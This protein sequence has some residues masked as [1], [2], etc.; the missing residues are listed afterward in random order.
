M[1]QALLPCEPFSDGELA[2]FRRFIREPCA[3][4]NGMLSS[5]AERW[6]FCQ[7]H[8]LGLL[9]VCASIPRS[10]LN[11][12]AVLYER[13]TRNALVMLRR[14]ASTGDGCGP[15]LRSEESC[16]MCELGLN[17]NSAGLIRR[18]WLAL[19]QSLERLRSLLNDT[20]ERWSPLVCST[21]VHLAPGPLCRRHMAEALLARREAIGVS[22]AGAPTVDR[23]LA[24]LDAL[25][26]QLSTYL[27]TFLP[28]S[29]GVDTGEGA[30]A[31]IAAAGWCTGWEMLLL[32]LG[33]R[34][35][36]GAARRD[37]DH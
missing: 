26:Q 18:E 25:E 23:E 10:G 32:A 16:P 27:E 33:S 11:T 1:T 19:P 15:S 29:A 9:A 24:L 31:L 13:T 17:A 14:C 5:T 35:V 12:A 7:R 20:F 3:N 30:A 36:G 28:E 22:T 34:R 8:T 37:V 2:F 4:R 6:G 21:C